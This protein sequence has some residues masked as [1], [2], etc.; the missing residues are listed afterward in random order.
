MG[1]GLI[2][3]EI[4][5]AQMQSYSRFGKPWDIKYIENTHT[6]KTWWSCAIT[7]NN[8]IQTLALKIISLTPHN[9]SCE[10]IFSILGWFCNKRRTR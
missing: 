4:L 3:S 10:R 2:S 9:I 7:S 1:G 8:Y 5:I 6:I